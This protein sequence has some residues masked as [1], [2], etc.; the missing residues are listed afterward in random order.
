MWVEGSDSAG[1]SIDGGGLTDNG[2]QALE[3]ST[4]GP[5]AARSSYRLEF[6]QASFSINSVKMTPER[7]A[8]GDAV[9]LDINL[10]NAGTRTGNV[11]LAVFSVIENGFPVNETSITTQDIPAGESMTVT[12]KLEEFVDPT[13]S[14][15]FFIV[16]VNNPT[17]ELWNGSSFEKDF[18]VR[19]SSQQDNSGLTTI[20][21]SG[22][23]ALVLILLVVIVVLVRRSGE[24]EFEYEDDEKDLVDL[25]EQSAYVAPQQSYGSYDASGGGSSDYT[26]ATD[27]GTGGYGGVSSEMQR[28]LQLFPQWD[29]ATIQGYFDMGWSIEQLQDWVTNN[30]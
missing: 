6:D 24:S 3:P 18:T 22:L 15:Y 28:A 30:G 19:V 17:V 25:P 26:T 14:M 8:V 1:W 2:V 9:S 13:T 29:Q 10:L 4:D 27:Y 23:A 11:T 21:F 16:D 7:P 12:V 5:D 20:L